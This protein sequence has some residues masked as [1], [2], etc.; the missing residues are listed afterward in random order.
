MT[1]RNHR[2]TPSKKPGSASNSRVWETL[3]LPSKIESATEFEKSVLAIRRAYT[4]SQGDR[5][6]LDLT[7]YL[8][9]WLVG[10]AGK[11][12]SPTHPWARVELGLTRKHPENL[13]LGDFVMNCISLIGITCGRIKDGETC[14]REPHGSYRWM[15]YFSEVFF[16]FHT[17][18]LGLQREEL[19]SYDSVKM[20]WLLTAS[21]DSILW[22]LRGVADSDGTVNVRNKVVAITSEPNGPFFAKLFALVGVRATLY[23]SKGYDCVS[24]SVTDAARVRIFNPE[25]VTHRNRLLNRLAAAQTFQARW[26]AWLEE[27]A[28][29]LLAENTDLSAVRNTLLFEDDTYVTLRTLRTKLARM[30]D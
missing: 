11:N 21:P 29:Q 16:W 23:N 4:G 15:S 8:L 10:D 17:S 26:P 30:G 20:D 25:L 18:C 12:F 19:T 3:T 13:Q 14:A 28:R 7:Y 6:F 27:R 5:R 9:G 2:C 22:F 1:L 24:I